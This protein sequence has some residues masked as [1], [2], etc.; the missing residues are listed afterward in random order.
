MPKLYIRH[1]AIERIAFDAALRRCDV[2][3]E[4]ALINLKAEFYSELMTAPGT[5]IPAGGI[6]PAVTVALKCGLAYICTPPDY[7]IEVA[8]GGIIM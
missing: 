6:P 3:D 1:E 8:E 7:A 4:D 5:T 2:K